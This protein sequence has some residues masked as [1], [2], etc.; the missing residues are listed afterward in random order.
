M[1]AD[2]EIIAGCRSDEKQGQTTRARGSTG[3]I[4]KRHER[5]G[6][7]MKVVWLRFGTKQRIS[8]RKHSKGFL[9]SESGIDK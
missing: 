8:E 1:A 4:E 6:R 9:E 5:E 2:T 7:V 3:G